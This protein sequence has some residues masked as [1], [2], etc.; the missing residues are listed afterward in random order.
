MQ[1]LYNEQ[2]ENQIKKTIP[3]KI[4]KCEILRNE[5]NQEGVRL[6][7]KNYENIIEIN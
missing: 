2:S 3:F 7:H 5:F 1:F 6:T 4:K